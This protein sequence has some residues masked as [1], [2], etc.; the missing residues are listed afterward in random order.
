[1][2]SIKDTILKEFIEKNNWNNLCPSVIGMYVRMND[3]IVTD[4]YVILNDYNV[5]PPEVDI[6]HDNAGEITAS[7]SDTWSSYEHYFVLDKN[8]K[9]ISSNDKIKVFGSDNS[10]L[11]KKVRYDYKKNM[12]TPLNLF[13]RLFDRD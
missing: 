1:M 6:I 10:L 11:V 3:N 5:R 7:L 12:F 9:K 13:E 8:G 4:L 2:N